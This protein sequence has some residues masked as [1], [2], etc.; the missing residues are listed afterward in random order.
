MTSIADL[1]TKATPTWCPGCGDF[2]IL[3]TIKNAI[4][5]AGLEP[6]NTVVCSGIGCGSKLPHYV[7]TYGFESL[8]GRGL[9]IATGIK[10]ANN[11]LNVIAVGGDGDTYGIGGNHFMHSMRRNLDITLIVQDN[12]IYG[13]TKGQTSPTSQRGFKSNSTPFG[14]LE[15]PVNP[16]NWAIAAGATY[17]ARGFALDI[18]HLKKLI[19]DA[20]KHKGFALVDVLQPCVTYN[21]AN[22]ADWYKQRIYKLEETEHDPSDKYAA[23]KMGEMMWTDKIPIGLFYKTEKPTY[24]EGLPQI[25]KQPLAKQD[26]SNIDI[27]GLLKKYK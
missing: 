11:R 17:V 12:A 1:T 4:V 23:I 2:T 3:S 24:E 13:L 27:S 10:L 22:T 8:H 25:A 15:E 26:I 9:T 5:E 7:K 14:A 16:V 18:I 6:H 19:V 21:K 20:M